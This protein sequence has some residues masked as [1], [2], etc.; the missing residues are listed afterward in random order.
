MNFDASDL[1]WERLY[2]ETITK[3]G[4]RPGC[5]VCYRLSWVLRCPR[6]TSVHLN[7]GEF[8]TVIQPSA[9]PAH[10][11]LIR[12]DRWPGKA[13]I[14]DVHVWRGPEG[15]SAQLVGISPHGDQIVSEYRLDLLEGRVQAA[16]RSPDHA[17]GKKYSIG[18]KDW[19]DSALFQRWMRRCHQEHGDRCNFIDSKL[20]STSPRWLVDTQRRCLVEAEPGQPYVALS[21]VWGAANQYKTLREDLEQLQQEGYLD[22]AGVAIPRTIRD[23]IGLVPLIG[24][25]YLWVDSLCILQEDGDELW[26]QIHGMAS[27]YA[28]ATV[29][30]VAAQGE[31]A[32]FGLRG[33]KGVSKPRSLS[34]EVHALCDGTQILSYGDGWFSQL[35]PT[36]YAH[37][38]W[39]FQ[40]Y[41]F[42]RRKI[43]FKDDSVYW[44]CEAA[45]WEEDIA[46]IHY[47]RLELGLGSAS[48]MGTMLLPRKHKLLQ[49]I[50][51]LADYARLVYAF[52]TKELTYPE[53]LPYSFAGMATMLSRSFAGGII[54]G[55]PA[56]FF[57]VALLWGS[58]EACMKR[59]VPLAAQDEAVDILPSW[60]W[61]GWQGRID[62]EAW[63]SGNDC[64]LQALGESQTHTVPTVVWFVRESVET[65]LIKVESTWCKHRTA[66]EEYG[67]K[68]TVPP[69]W[70][71]HR[72]PLRDLVRG[73]YDLLNHPDGRPWAYR[74]ASARK[75]DIDEFAL[76]DNYAYPVPLADHQGAAGPAAAPAAA[77]AEELQ[78]V[79]PKIFT[80]LLS[81]CTERTWLYLGRRGPDRSVQDVETHAWRRIPG[82]FSVVDADGEWVGILQSNFEGICDI[83]PRGQRIELVA[84]SR[85]WCWED[86]E[87][88]DDDDDNG[89]GDGEGDDVVGGGGSRSRSNTG[90]SRSSSR[91][92]MHAA[93][94]KPIEE[95][96]YEKRPRSG[97]EKYE[98]YNVLW[99]E[100][101]KGT[102]YRKSVGR[103]ERSA[104]ERQRKDSTFLK[105]A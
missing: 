70:T 89:G 14:Q 55:L 50:P 39:T 66:I 10:A 28:N 15:S 100:R 63:R 24:G 32:D 25:R 27:I 51:S 21:Y 23:A 59:R 30:I 46:Q 41:L 22:D 93:K 19:I 86:V 96:D 78:L 101:R 48:S 98:W 61:M 37:R 20:P 105:L 72:I 38:A 5:D 77:A 8:T 43:M 103:V 40:E 42:S 4:S 85:G 95:W 82:P 80:P 18:D 68:D 88:D 71:R 45:T 29:T 57:D 64:L 2:Q 56:M 75:P 26:D 16:A 49:P 33:I 84:L 90:M 65:D 60:S 102:A 91:A 94:R 47:P 81:A 73:D 1:H 87:D 62:A 53:D 7:L 54:C 9:C 69:G 99:I 52:N 79:A 11:A 74:H 31:T 67:A 44:K 6:G 76:H 17:P 12:R 35:V 13:Q 58:H 92:R 36:K 97:E 83:E 34:D 104:W 3:S